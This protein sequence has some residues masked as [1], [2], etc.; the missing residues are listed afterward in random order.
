VRSAVAV[1]LALGCTAAHGAQQTTST[2]APRASTLTI[3]IR[4]VPV[5]TEQ[6]ALERTAGGW[7]LTSSG[8]MGAPIDLITRNLQVRYT[9]D[10]KPLELSI[11]ATLKGQPLTSRTTIT[12]GNATTTFTEA[13]QS[14]ER[15][16]AIAPDA[17]LLPSPFWGAFEALAERL[18][19]ASAGSTI[20]AYSLQ[21]EFPIEVGESS[22]EVI[23]VGIRAVRARRTLVR[24]IAPG[25]APL[26]AEVWGDE[27]GRLI[28][29]S[30]PAQGVEVVREDVASVAARRVIVSRPGDEQVWISGNG[31]SLAGTLSKPPTAAAGRLPSVVLIGGSGLTDRDETTFGIP[32]FGQLAGQ[33]ADAGFLVLRY[34]KRGV[35][36]S[37]G[38]P[39]AAT[40]ADYADDVRSAIE[41]LRRRKDVDRNRIALVGHSEGGSVAM[42]T[43]AK[44]DRIAAVVL[45]DA[46]GVTGAEV[47]LEQV[48]HAV[49]RTTRSEADKQATIEL[50]KRIQRAVLTGKG[51]EGIP[52]NIRRQADIPWFQSFLAFDP[53]KPMADMRQPVLI[54]QSMLDTQV[55]PANADR[56]EQLAKARKRGGPVDVVKVPGINHLL[57]PAATGEPEEYATLK[58]KQISPA[59]GSG[60]SSWLQKIFTSIR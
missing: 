8:R 49:S 24:L 25:V 44:N 57:V 13:G 30:I 60:I 54:V 48:T 4:S 43:A 59:V 29:L 33:L 23:D 56:L 14:G 17:V 26:D 28:R 41:F 40:L 37:G 22:D 53:A 47:N 19:N 42:L 1:L 3:F 45:I 7:T 35:G 12:G 27:N 5:G 15:T 21:G 58:S 34:D 16:A 2:P 55:A 51:W 31:F 52:A 36:Q 11:D 32:I 20:P 46:I 10:W 39:E 6:V 38:R 18:K 9:E 50:Q